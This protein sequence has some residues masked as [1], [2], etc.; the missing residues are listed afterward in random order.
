MHVSRV[1]GAG[2]VAGILGVLGVGLL[3][4]S[5]QRLNP[6]F[7]P[8]SDGTTAPRASS[9]AKNTTQESGP[10]GSSSQ[11]LT[12][13]SSTQSSD[14]HTSD[15]QSNSGASSTK[16]VSTEAGTTSSSETTG[17]SM[18]APAICDGTE[19]LCFALNYDPVAKVYPELTGKGPPMMLVQG[20]GTLTAQSESGT[21]VFADF[22][23][24]DGGGRIRINEAVDVGFNGLYGFDVTVRDIR[25]SEANACYVSVTGDLALRYS[26]IDSMIE[27]A[28][29][30]DGREKGN[31]Q[32]LIDPKAV[33]NFACFAQDDQIYLFVNGETAIGHRSVLPVPRETIRFNVGSVPSTE[34]FSDFVGDIGRFRY[35]TSTQAMQ[36]AVKAGK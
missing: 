30:A 18:P 28:S 1:F 34:E 33:N 5:C 24:V 21:V 13:T 36:R 27:C 14:S 35:W 19:T 15:S 22:F 3:S 32:K 6:A 7:L 17:T 20:E 26:A 10:A 16:T 11:D 25:C 2:P 23:R 12:Q 31:A 8:D 9:A 29:F 4:F